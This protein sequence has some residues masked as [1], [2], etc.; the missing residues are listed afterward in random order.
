M[1]NNEVIKSKAEPRDV[2]MNISINIDDGSNKVD[3]V[4]DAFAES[5]RLKQGVNK[6]KDGAVTTAK[7]SISFVVIGFVLLVILVALGIIS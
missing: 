7:L 5:E 4:I 1:N 2:N 3:K 6:I